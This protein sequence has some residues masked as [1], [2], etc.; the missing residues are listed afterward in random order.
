M[1]SATLDARV[2]A[3]L[4]RMTVD[5]ELRLIAGDA[6]MSVPGLPALGIPALH[7]SDGP[8]G[9]RIPNPSTAYAAGIGLAATWDPALAR[10]IGVQLGRDARARGAHFLLGP[11]VNIYRTPLNGRN[12]EYFGEDPFLVSRIAVGYI[13]GVQSQGV[14]ATIKHY[15]GNNSEYARQ[16]SDSRIDERA[17][18]E[19][20]LPAFE[21]AVREAKV[22]AVMSAYNRTNGEHM[23]ENAYLDTQVLKRDW[24]FDGLLMSDWGS[25][26]DT[27][28]A[29][30]AGL[31]LEMPSAAVRNARA[32]KPALASGVVSREAIDDKVRRLLR[33]AAH[34]GWL[35]RPQL[36]LD[37]PRYNEA[38]RDLSRRST[39][40]GMVL[41]RNEDHTLPLNRRDVHVLAL[42]GPDAFPAIPTAGGSGMV[43]TYGAVSP[44][45]ALSD[46]LGT[47]A[48]VLYDRGVRTRAEVV[49]STVFTTIAAGGVRGVTIERYNNEHLAGTP[50]SVGV[51][52][53]MSVRPPSRDPD[54]AESTDAAAPSAGDPDAVLSGAT[55]AS[56]LRLTGYFTPPSAGKYVVT[57][58]TSNRFRL[59]V[60]DRLV[61]DDAQIL[62]GSGRHALVTLDAQPHKIVVEQ[63]HPPIRQAP[64]D[65]LQCGLARADELVSASA[66]A[67][68]A[69]A[70]VAIVA[71][72]FDPSTEGEGFDRE[73]ALPPEQEALIEQVAAV[74]PR[75]IVV[76]TS[77]GSVATSPWLAHSAALIEGW[78]AGEEGGTALAQ[79]LFGDAN[80]SGRLPISWE[81]QLADNPSYPYY[82][83]DDPAT[84]QIHYGEGIYVGYRG[85][86]RNRVSPLF[87]FGYG[88]SYTS[89]RYGELRV[90][91][92][93]PAADGIRFD[94]SFDVSNTGARAGTDVA[95]VYV[96]DTTHPGVERPVKELKGFARL[97]LRPG[98]TQ[99]AHIALDARAFS[100]YDVQSR[101]WRANAGTYRIQV[102]RSSAN[103]VLSGELR[104]EQAIEI[105]VSGATQAFH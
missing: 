2:N 64:D 20:Y 5:D 73:F 71:V 75:T 53:A 37:V 82:Y 16:T 67:M 29:S 47:D 25:T 51:L 24:R 34:F 68:A 60:D 86:D 49:H 76:V 45:T 30:N 4:A 42:L 38:G 35:D 79:L 18:R 72:G 6:M 48:R 33:V 1:Q 65:F 103:I 19:I 84:Q 17:L 55:T 46:Y 3:L 102:G 97:E 52:P 88:L 50:T 12:F 95:Q 104:L 61:L 58:Q 56:S 27:V 28:A 10:E 87:P 22:G 90:R 85:Y 78:Y 91:R 14:S 93:L 70:D 43:E 94:V 13:D 32:L 41:L 100:Y 59:L 44:L 57:L 9:T 92:M 54:A 21:A 105:P 83:Y 23:S 39:L 101:S 89:F 36:D 80:F 31:D 15:V 77:G 96:S 26:Y 66:L 63:F 99:R 40:E 62:K 81:R 8:F 98:Q 7:M 74:N 11:G 69:R